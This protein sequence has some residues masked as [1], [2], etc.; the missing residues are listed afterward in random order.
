MRYN[1]ARNVVKFEGLHV[2]SDEILQARRDGAGPDHG[3][4][5]GGAGPCR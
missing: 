4:V 5:D 3:R 2:F 1:S